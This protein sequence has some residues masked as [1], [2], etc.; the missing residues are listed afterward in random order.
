MY[1]TIVAVRLDECEL[2]HDPGDMSTTHILELLT[3]KAI[4]QAE[5]VGDFD[6]A[7]LLYER[8]PYRARPS[9]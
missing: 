7:A 9:L 8:D 2:E 3:C 5:T 4:A 1:G 6:A